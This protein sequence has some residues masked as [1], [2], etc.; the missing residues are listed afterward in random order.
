VIDSWRK[1]WRLPPDARSLT[2]GRV[3]SIASA[4]NSTTRLD[5]GGDG[6]E[7]RAIYFTAPRCRMPV[8]EVTDALLISNPPVY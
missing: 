8:R 7:D 2:G 5:E 6:N 1:R 3:A 4:K